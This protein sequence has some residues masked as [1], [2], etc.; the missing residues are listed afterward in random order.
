MGFDS[1]GAVRKRLEAIG[2]RPLKRLGQNF[3]SDRNWIRKAVDPIPDGWPIVE[4]G[5]G[6][7]A[8]TEEALRR[9]HSVHAVE[10]DSALC[11]HLKESITDPRFTLYE[12]DAV[13][14]PLGKFFPD[15]APF[16]LLSNLPFSITSPWLDGL[17]RRE[18]PLPQIM[19]L[20]LQKEGLART[21]ALPRTKPY[22]P[23]A[24][25]ASL[26]FQFL[27]GET[28]PASAFHPPPTVESRFGVWELRPDPRLLGA[29]EI[30][31][32]RRFFGQ[33]R[34]MLRQGMK[35]WLSAGES[36]RWTQILETHQ[37]SPTCR[38]EEI[39]PE[40]WWELLQPRSS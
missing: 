29:D 38:A 33:R 37:L 4:I 23:T 13:S 35:D 25:R 12:G 24:I 34:K 11:R 19:A 40:L 28:V 2:V 30:Q 5:P 3:L 10:M 7:G 27:S 20:I 9:G 8:L 6:L 39:S 16:A 14:A 31:L 15:D 18:R 17:L 22:G 1:P 36:L 26:A 32:L 21:H